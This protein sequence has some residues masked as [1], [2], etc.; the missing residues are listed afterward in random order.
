MIFNLFLNFK[1][2]EKM[3]C[4]LI[5]QHFYNLFQ[6]IKENDIVEFIFYIH[7]IKEEED[8]NV[9]NQV[10]SKNDAKEIIDEKG[11]MV[12]D[13]PPLIFLCIDEE[14]YDYIQVLIF[15]QYPLDLVFDGK[16]IIEYLLLKCV[17]KTNEE[18]ESILRF[19]FCNPEIKNKMNLQ[20]L[21]PILNINSY[22]KERI[23]K[24]YEQKDLTCQGCLEE[25]PNQMAHMDLGGC[26]YDEDYI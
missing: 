7:K 15:N 23:I 16:D 3:H 17:N 26:M 25:Q 1:I 24:I 19:V 12:K 5:D 21:Q 4:Y 14:R 11:E 2:K 8:Q 13:Y 6:I 20:K 22:L 9:L 10:F 18:L